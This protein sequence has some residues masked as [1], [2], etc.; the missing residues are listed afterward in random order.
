MGF[1][2]IKECIRAVKQIHHLAVTKT[3]ILDSSER[4]TS[5]AAPL[6]NIIIGS[7]LFHLLELNAPFSTSKI[8]IPIL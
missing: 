7:R 5:V 6:I 2:V 3:W 4:K 8:S 1:L